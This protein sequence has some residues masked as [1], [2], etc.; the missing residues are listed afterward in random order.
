MSIESPAPRIFELEGPRGA[1]F[2]LIF[3]IELV[4]GIKN[5]Q[6]RQ[7]TFYE[8]YEKVVTSAQN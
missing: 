4:S 5:I 8:S 2:M 1:N 6:V 3:W 7:P